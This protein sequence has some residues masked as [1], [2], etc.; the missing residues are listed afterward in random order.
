MSGRADATDTV[1]PSADT[2]V[3]VEGDLVAEIPERARYRRGQTPQSFRKSIIDRAYREAAAVGDVDAAT[4]AASS[5]ATSRAHASWPFRRRGEPEDHDAHGHGARG[6]DDPAADVGGR[7]DPLPTRSLRGA[8]LYVW[9]GR[10]GSARR[11]PR[12]PRGRGDAAVAGRRTASTSAGLR[13]GGGAPLGRRRRNSAGPTSSAGRRPAHGPG[14]RSQ[15]RG[16]RRGGAGRERRR[17]PSTG[18][19][20]PRALAGAGAR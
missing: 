20:R 14:H 4:T 19:R 17:Q 16:A 2:L 5:C 9:A 15:P 3:V 1:I 12:R 8:R 10:T 13:R 6:P 18:A 7:A 11:S